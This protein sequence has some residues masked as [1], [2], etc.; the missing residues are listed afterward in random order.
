[1]TDYQDHQTLA[2]LDRAT[3][4]AK[5]SAFRAFKQLSGTWQEGRD[6]TLLTPATDAAAIAKLKAEG[7]AYASSLSL[8]LLG[9]E[10]A[11]QVQ[12]LLASSTGRQR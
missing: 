5:G 2:E 10:P 3:G 4:S 1:M 6:Y 9:P 12:A 8:L 11:R 7:R